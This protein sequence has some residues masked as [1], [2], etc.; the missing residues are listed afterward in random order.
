MEPTAAEKQDLSQWWTSQAITPNARGSERIPV[1]GDC[2]MAWGTP[3]DSD[4]A[5]SDL[6]NP[7]PFVTGLE[8]TPPVGPKGSMAYFCLDRHFHAVNIAFL[9]GHAE[10]ITAGRSLEAEMEQHLQAAGCRA[11]VKGPSRETVK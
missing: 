1:F 4:T 6:I 8:K 9:D 11:A 2:I 5:P 7:L 3:T 10:N